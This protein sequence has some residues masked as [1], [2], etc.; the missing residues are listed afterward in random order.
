MGR[1]RAAIPVAARALASAPVSGQRRCRAE[2]RRGVRRVGEGKS[3]G[4]VR[5]G[6]GVPDRAIRGR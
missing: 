6:V 5:T 2:R 3:E 1:A 4:T